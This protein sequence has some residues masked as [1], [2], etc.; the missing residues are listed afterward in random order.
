MFGLLSVVAGT[1]V[2][3][4]GFTFLVFRS[5]SMG[6]DIPTGSL[7]LARTTDAADLRSG[8]V[9]SVLAANGER[10]T[11]RLVTST[12]RGDEA[13]L[14]LQGDANGTPDDE[15][16]QVTEAEVEIASVPFAGYVVAV[17]LSPAGLLAAGCLSL[18]LLLMGFGPSDRGDPP[19][20]TGGGGKHRGVR[21]R[22]VRRSVVLAGVGLSM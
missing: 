21:A 1:A 8:D 4:F 19:S 3:F 2:M 14:V 7:A 13:S 11:H 12:L 10:V 5:G 20:T 16:Y 18:M 22:D 15:I 9:V 17:L 6:P